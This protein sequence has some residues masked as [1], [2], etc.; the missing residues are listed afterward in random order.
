MMEYSTKL[1]QL[2]RERPGFGELLHYD[3][4][5]DGRNRKCGDHLKL[6]IQ[7]HHGKLVDLKYQGDACALCMASAS[8][9]IETLRGSSLAETLESYQALQQVL[10]GNKTTTE[11]Q[12]FSG[13]AGKTMRSGCIDLPWKTLFQLDE[14]W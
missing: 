11:F 5:L 8:L 1:K 6:Y 2:A 13:W 14:P 3:H 4:L 12:M 7:M 10:K 9:M